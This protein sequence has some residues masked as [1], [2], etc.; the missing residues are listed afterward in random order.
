MRACRS[1][2]SPTHLGRGPRERSPGRGA[3]SGAGDPGGDGAPLPGGIHWGQGGRGELVGGKDKRVDG[4]CGDTLW[5]RPKAP[6]VCL[7]RTAEVTP[8]GVRIRAAG[9]PGSWRLLWTGR[10]GF[11]GD[12]R[13]G[14]V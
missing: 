8:T 5:G 4:V 7:H 6:A 1:E 2:G 14:V 11:E 10:Y 3:L 12:L 9:D 13:A